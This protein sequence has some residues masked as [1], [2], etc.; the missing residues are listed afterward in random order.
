MINASN[1]PHKAYILQ[2]KGDNEHKYLNNMVG[3]YPAIP[4]KVKRVKPD[5]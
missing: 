4:M 1:Y 5:L 3:R 2:E